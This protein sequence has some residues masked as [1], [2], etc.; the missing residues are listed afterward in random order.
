M[1]MEKNSYRHSIMIE[2][3]SQWQQVVP[4][5]SDF[6]NRDGETPDDWDDLDIV[7]SL[8]AAWEWEDLKMRDL[9]WVKAPNGNQ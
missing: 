2:G 5:P 1:D 7:I 4:S 3:D 6:K 8:P 9:M